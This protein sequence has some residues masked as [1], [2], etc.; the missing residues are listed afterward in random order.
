MVSLLQDVRTF[1]S[2]DEQESFYN[3][4]KK[5]AKV[6]QD[7]FKYAY[8]ILGTQRL[9][10]IIGIFK[11]LAIKQGKINYLKYLPRTKKLI[12]YNLRNSIFND[13]KIWLEKYG[14]N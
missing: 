13:L 7:D 5:H 1:L 9:F 8:L 3:Y 6:K 14:N 10:K 12:K 4:Y 2:I 11:K